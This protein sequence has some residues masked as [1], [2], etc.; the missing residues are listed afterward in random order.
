MGQSTIRGGTPFAR[1]RMLVAAIGAIVAAAGGNAIAAQA[2]LANL[3]PYEG[4]G[5]G[6]TKRHDR[7]GTA[8]AQR[9]AQKRRN[10]QRHR[11]ACRG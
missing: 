4:R 2:Q 11:K 10:Q 5:K 8:S 9:A 7:G 3:A 6:K 1:A